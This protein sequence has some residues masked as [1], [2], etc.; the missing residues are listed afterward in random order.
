[1]AERDSGWIQIYAENAQEAYDSLIQAFRIAENAKILLPVMVCLDGFTLSHTLENVCVLPDETVRAFVGIR[2]LPLVRTHEGKAVP[3]KLDAK[4]PLTLGPIALPNYYF[5][6]K[7]QQ[8][9]GMQEALKS[10]RQVHD[11]YARISGRE[12]GD[13]LLDPY[14]I[15]DA[16]IAVICM[17][18]S[19]GTG[20]TVVNALRA[21][22]VA[23]GLLRIRTFRPIPSK[24]IIKT[25]ENV[26]AVAVMDRS[27]SFGG[28]GGPLFHEIRHALYDAHIHP[29]VVNYI[30]GLGGRDTSPAQIRKI[31]EALQRSLEDQQV[32]NLVQYVELRE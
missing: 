2:Q 1:M 20:K 8:E 14:R 25:I 17:G 6:F 29:R 21:E 27:L 19:A 16:E 13:G 7:R 32:G 28:V 22:G 12:Y 10:I 31:F 9:E 30:Y 24:E 23:A 5:E 4:T 26:K 15:Q 18:S 3:F 11:E